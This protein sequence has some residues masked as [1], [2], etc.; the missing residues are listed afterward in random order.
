[1]MTAFGF[2]G[3]KA[4]EVHRLKF[5]HCIEPCGGESWMFT[6]ATVGEGFSDVSVWRDLLARSALRIVIF[7]WCDRSILLPN[8]KLLQLGKDN[9][10]TQQYRPFSNCI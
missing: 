3:S 8:Q 10:G 2:F 6:D 5:R 1:M 9:E 4:T 7:R